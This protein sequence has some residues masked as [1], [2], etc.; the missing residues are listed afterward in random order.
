MRVKLGK[1][2]RLAGNLPA[3][4]VTYEWC[5]QFLEGMTFSPNNPTPLRPATKNRY[6]SMISTA[7][8]EAHAKDPTVVVPKLPS[9]DENNFKERYLDPA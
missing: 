6:K 1:L 9:W 4:R 2:I 7:F 3:D 8:T 5:Y